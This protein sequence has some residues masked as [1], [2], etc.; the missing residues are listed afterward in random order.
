KAVAFELE[1]INLDKVLLNYHDL[2]RDQEYELFAK[3]ATAKLVAEDNIFDILVEGDVQ[4]H[5]IRIQEDHFFK[6]KA[7]KVKASL[8]YH[9]FKDSLNIRPS[10]IF[11]HDSEFSVQGLYHGADE[12]LVHISTEGENTDVQT[13]LSLMS[14]K[15][16]NRFKVYRSEGNI[17][18]K[19]ELDG[20]ISENDFPS[21][22]ISFGC[23]DASFF[24]PDI[25]RKI[26]DVTLEGSFQA[27]KAN[28][29]ATARLNLGQVSGNLEGRSFSGSLYI[30]NFN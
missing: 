22:E 5:K 19:A 26:T 30:E 9:L 2:R 15:V 27:E 7:L 3:T 12:N 18:F 25:S 1:K 21:L 4:S 13:L 17:Y 23:R 8:N 16:Y 20:T 14:E 29:P 11:V 10:Q 28:D 24:H 6:D